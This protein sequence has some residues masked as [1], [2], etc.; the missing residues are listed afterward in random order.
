MSIEGLLR[1]DHLVILVRDLDTAVKNYRRL[2]LTVAP[3]GRHADG[4]TYNALVVFADDTYLELV[5]FTNRWMLARLRLLRRLGLLDRFVPEE[6][7]F[8]CRLRRRGAVTEGLVDYALVPDADDV[9][10]QIAEARARGLEI[11]G[12]FPGGRT[13]PDGQRVAWQFGFP[14]DQSLPFLCAD[15]TSRHLRVPEGDVRTHANRALAIASVTIEVADLEAASAAYGQ[16]LGGNPVREAEGQAVFSAGTS[17]VLRQ[18]QAERGLIQ[19]TLEVAEGNA[20]GPLDGRLTEDVEI[21]MVSRQ[22]HPS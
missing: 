2:G 4:A 3:G 12:P 20:V 22:E 1:L 16:L 10:R 14:Y 13:R 9:T 15:T 17:I 21:D 5:A 7:S 8:G 18:R 11:D 19:V 6:P